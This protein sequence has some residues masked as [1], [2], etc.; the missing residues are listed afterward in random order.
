MAQFSCC[1]AQLQA[2]GKKY[3][4]CATQWLKLK[5]KTNGTDEISICN[6]TMQMYHFAVY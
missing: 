6:Y 3:G 1:E 4:T 2:I 5:Q